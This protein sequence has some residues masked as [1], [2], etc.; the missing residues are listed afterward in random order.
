MLKSICDIDFELGW[1][2]VWGTDIWVLVLHTVVTF[3]A[4]VPIFQDVVDACLQDGVCPHHQ[5]DVDGHH[6]YQS[7]PSD[8]VVKL[9]GQ[10][11]AMVGLEEWEKDS[12]V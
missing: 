6:N 4:L 8:A 11:D 1:E 9:P 12:F 5:V 7:W 3:V 10:I 2:I